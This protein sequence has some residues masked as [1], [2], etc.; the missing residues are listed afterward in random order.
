MNLS[1][2]GKIILANH[3][4]FSALWHVVSVWMFDK[5]AI[6][7]VK[8]CIRGFLW[9]GNRKDNATAKVSWSTLIFP[10]S[11]HCLGLIDLGL[12]SQSLLCKVLVMSLLPENELWKTLI[13]NRSMLWGPWFGG[14]WKPHK[15]WLFCMEL[16]FRKSNQWADHTCMS[17]MKASKS[18]MFNY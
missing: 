14:H 1:L 17:V 7:I 12:Q 4:L 6:R 8:A 15:S 11:K 16:K 5:H 9:V 13:H 18:D 10:K 2:A 3:V